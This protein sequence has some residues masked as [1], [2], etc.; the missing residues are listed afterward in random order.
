LAEHNIGMRAKCR[1]KTDLARQ[2]IRHRPA[3][4]GLENTSFY[5]GM[6]A[7]SRHESHPI[8][9]CPAESSRLLM[10]LIHL[11]CVILFFALFLNFVEHF[12]IFRV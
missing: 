9:A 8:H 12:S 1:E 11:G 4:A 10:V 6:N 5:A 7:A 2:I 3:A